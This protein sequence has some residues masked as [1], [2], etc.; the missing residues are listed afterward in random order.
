[1]RRRG[2]EGINEALF[3]LTA[4]TTAFSTFEECDVEF[5]ALSPSNGCNRSTR[6][7]SGWGG[8][9]GERSGRSYPP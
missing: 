1:M 7:E 2:A 9:G 4:R 3:T 8:G 5:T 6:P